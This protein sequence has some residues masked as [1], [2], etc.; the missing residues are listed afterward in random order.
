M[1][2]KAPVVALVSSPGLTHLTPL[3][4]F[5]KR[6]SSLYPHDF[7][8]KFLV[9]TLGP[10]SPTMKS[11]LQSLPSTMSFVLLPQ[12]NMEDLPAPDFDPAAQV[13]LTVSL[14]LPSI[15]QQ[16]KLLSSSSS[17]RLIALVVDPFAIDAINIAKEFSIT[18]YAY[19]PGSAFTACFCLYLPKLHETTSLEFRDLSETIRLPGCEPVHG[20]DLPTPAQ[21]RSSNSYRS[22]L[23]LC[24]SLHLVD[25]IIINSF[26]NLETGPF[27]ALQEKQAQNLPMF[28]PV[29][30]I[31]GATA[32][33]NTTSDSSIECL[34]WLDDQPLN[35]VLYVSFGSGGTL[36]QDQLNELALGLELSGH[37]FLWIVRVPSTSASSAYLN[38]QKDDPLNYLPSGFL[39]RTKDQGL[40]V[41]SWAPQIEVLNH[42][43]T[44]GFLSHCG[45]NST[46]E[47]IVNGKPVI[48]WPLFAEQKMNALLL[49]DSLKVALRPTA[50]EKGLAEGKEVAKVIKTLKDSEEGIQIRKRME[51]L[52]DA[53]AEAL[54]EDGSSTR[55]LSELALKWKNLSG[56]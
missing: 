38:A 5:A 18:S 6:L 28:Y 39:E 34:R 15:H 1:A 37:K 31:T 54:K 26:I 21:D 43:S 47:S 22:F 36:S 45:W 3:V 46:L 44:F 49:C 14:S 24:Q 13:F 55:S 9:T 32:T 56:T 4:E 23:H 20:S 50:N 12:V 48:A 51:E 16:I 42:K 52:Q 2:E 27:R 11:V 17:T 10:P 53:A 8:F 29:G 40:V 33:S 41:P 35:S 30:P 19:Y 7:H 25:G